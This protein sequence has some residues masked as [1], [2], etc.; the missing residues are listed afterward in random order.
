[1]RELVF[2]AN[3]SSHHFCLSGFPFCSRLS[4]FPGFPSW[5]SSK[6][7]MLLVFKADGDGKCS[8]GYRVL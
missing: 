8:C 6:K 2:P 3:D 7:V 4:V 1:M 5:N